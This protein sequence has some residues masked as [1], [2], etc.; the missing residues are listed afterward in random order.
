MISDI[1]MIMEIEPDG[2]L[3]QVKWQT[4]EEEWCCTGFSDKYYLQ[5]FIVTEEHEGANSALWL[6]HTSF[7]P[8]WDLIEGCWK[9]NRLKSTIKVSSNEIRREASQDKVDP[10]PLNH[11]LSMI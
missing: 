3:C 11:I 2:R 10:S 7:S 8:K 6:K 9:M 1:G 5:S 4:G